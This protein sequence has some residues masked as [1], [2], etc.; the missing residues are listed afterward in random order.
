M[1]GR[2]DFGGGED[3]FGNGG[4]ETC[5]AGTFRAEYHYDFLSSRRTVGVGCRLVGVLWLSSS[6]FIDAFGQEF[7]VCCTYLDTYVSNRCFQ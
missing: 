4:E 2:A 6:V 5:F 3:V 1:V 7:G